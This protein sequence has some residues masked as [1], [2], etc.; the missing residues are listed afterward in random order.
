MPVIP[1]DS[2]QCEAERP[3]R[4]LLVDIIAVHDVNGNPIDTWTDPDS[5]ILWLRDLLPKDIKNARVLAYGYSAGLTSFFGPDSV[6]K[7]KN[8]AHTLVKEIQEYRALEDCSQRPIIFICHG[9]GGMLVKEALYCASMKTESSVRHLRSVFLSTYA[10]MFF[11]TPHSGLDQ[12]KWSISCLETS[13][14][15]LFGHHKGSLP[16]IALRRDA[17]TLNMIAEDFARLMKEFQIF[18]FWAQIACHHKDALEIEKPWGTEISP[19]GADYFIRDT[20]VGMVR[21]TSGHPSY[22]TVIVTLVRYCGNAPIVISRRWS[23]GDTQ[24]SQEDTNGLATI[25]DMHK[26][27]QP[28]QKNAYE[29]SCNKYFQIPQAVS[30]IFTGREDIFRILKT[31]LFSQ[32][33]EFA[34]QQK[35]FIIYGIGGSGK[36]QFTC[37]F[38]Q[39]LRESFWGVFW[40]D[41]TSTETAR[42]SFAK[43]GKLGGQEE[44]QDS[45]KHWLSHLDEPWLLIIN[46]AD[47]PNLDLHSL[48]PEG[49]RGCILVTSKNPNSC[50]YATVGSTEFAGLK[51][52]D[53]V[54]LL[55]KAADIP[56]P[57]D[58]GSRTTASQIANALGYLALALI[59]AGELVL[60]RICSLKEFL[61]FYN[62]YRFHLRCDSFRNREG[63]KRYM[64]YSTWD[65]S[66]QSLEKDQNEAS[67][68]AAQLLC[69]VA[70]FH[71]KH[72]RVDIFLRALYFRGKALETPKQTMFSGMVLRSTWKRL[73]SPVA[74]PEFL[75]QTP[76]SLSRY[77]VRKALHQLRSF[78]LISYDG[79]NNSFSLH[80]VVHAWARDRL[81]AGEQQLWAEVSL[82]TIAESIQFPSDAAGESYE[83]FRM[84]LLP[85][86]DFCLKA[87]PIRSL[88][89]NIRFGRWRTLLS[90]TLQYTS[91]LSYREEVLRAAKCAY[92]YAECGRFT[93]AAPLLSSVFAAL[94]QSRGC[95][96]VWTMRAM[97]T[98]AGAY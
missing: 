66:F 94:V 91:L 43:I 58:E 13:Q 30:S 47:D 96:K 54:A 6:R 27:N 97:L 50:I 23:N 57:W 80:P 34:R 83:N 33:P 21:L 12:G 9:L 4:S 62:A 24:L 5:Q 63:T 93:D 52:D 49:E 20:H 42:Q 22:R 40:I 55:L 51:E 74:L 28:F 7:I 15:G 59:Q 84:D 1:L 37:K 70:F 17:P 32:D 61:N 67:R 31:A 36:T 38:A 81:S 78:S 45:G 35:R 98:L 8:H 72:I 41:A 19:Y 76:S 60:Q 92:F 95:E 65:R 89:L 77:R 39:D 86:L 3:D 75:R 53:A 64:N 69:V 26:Y 71:F 25:F 73:R 29:K 10:I 82:N 18:S 16:R 56:K 90:L 11:G 48:F 87:S 88:D 85:H 68:D 46:N 14:K 44:T 2:D 79:S